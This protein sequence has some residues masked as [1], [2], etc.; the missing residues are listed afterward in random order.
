LPR[1]IY[2]QPALRVV[3]FFIFPTLGFAQGYSH[4]TRKAGCNFLY[5]SYT[6]LCPGL[7]IFNPLC[8][9]LLSLSFLP[10]AL[11]WVIYIQ[12]ALRVVTFFIFSTQG[13]ALG[14]SH[15]TRFAG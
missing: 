8:G 2:I 13:F 7:F 6:G 12:P 4:S 5:L 3:T 15:S 1:V 10:R 14:Y 11:P 9:L